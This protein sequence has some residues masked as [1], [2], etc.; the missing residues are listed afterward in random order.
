MR[1][2]ERESLRVTSNVFVSDNV[3]DETLMQLEGQYIAKTMKNL[4]NTNT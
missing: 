1:E 4:H 2:R 3:A